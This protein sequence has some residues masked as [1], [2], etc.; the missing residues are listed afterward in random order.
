MAK[1]RTIMSPAK[2]SKHFT[3]SEAQAVF[4]KLDRDRRTRAGKKAS[5]RQKS[6]A[7]AG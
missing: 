7:K 4:R 1:I 5:S 2:E 6:G 3:V